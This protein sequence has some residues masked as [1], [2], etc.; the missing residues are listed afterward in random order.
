MAISYVTSVTKGN[1]T[2]TTTITLTG[3]TCKVGDFMLWTVGGAAPSI[4]VPAAPAGWTVWEANRISGA[5]GIAMWY[6]IATSTDVSNGG[7]A[8]AYSPGTVTNGRWAAE[9][10]VFRGVNQTTPKDVANTLSSSISTFIVPPAITPVTA[11]AWVIGVEE[12][13][14]SSG[15]A[16]PTWASTNY[17]ALVG[18]AH[19]TIAANTNPSIIVGYFPW[20]SGAFTPNLTAST[21]TFGNGWGTS[22]VLR[23]AEL[24]GAA[25]IFF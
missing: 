17:T 18:E 19:S 4:V 16:A 21:G 12:A 25:S 3:P 8:N 22:S 2:V 7:V 13:T 11:G 24:P 5:N 20:A 10:S 6:K 1:S 15:S 9:M 14:L 23:P